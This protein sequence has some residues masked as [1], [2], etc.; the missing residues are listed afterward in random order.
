MFLQQYQNNLKAPKGLILSVIMKKLENM[1]IININ[2]HN[3]KN[4]LIFSIAIL[5][6]RSY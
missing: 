5:S 3:F 1:H 4:A 2:L 6:A